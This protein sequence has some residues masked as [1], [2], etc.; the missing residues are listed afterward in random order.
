MRSEPE[1]R[2]AVGPL[3]HRVTDRVDDAVAWVLLAAGLFLVVIAGATGLGVYGRESE[4]AE[5]ESASRWQARAVLLEDAQLVAGDVGERLP[6]RAMAHWTDRKG[7]DHS[8]VVDA[9][10][11]KPAGAEVQVW[12]DAAGDAAP[13][14][15]RPVNA[16]A[17]G[18]AAGFGVLCAG[19]TLLVALWFGVRGLTARHNA[20]RWAREWERVEP[21]WRRHLR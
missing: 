14:P 6:F 5:L 2:S 4:R 16:V 9:G 18:V 11:R 8:G 1:R 15:V 20:R 12:V 13:A 17:G 3:P 7:L 21:D 19:G 10:G